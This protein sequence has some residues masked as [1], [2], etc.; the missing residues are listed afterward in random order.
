MRFR[1]ATTTPSLNR[2]RSNVCIKSMQNTARFRSLCTRL[3]LSETYPQLDGATLLL[4][5]LRV[6]SFG[7]KFAD[8][9]FDKKRVKIFS[10]T[11]SV[12]NLDLSDIESRRDFVDSLPIYDKDRGMRFWSAVSFV[13]RVKDAVVFVASVDGTLT[14]CMPLSGS[15]IVVE[16][17]TLDMEHVSFLASPEP[18]SDDGKPGEPLDINSLATSEA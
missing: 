1:P 11:K 14:A 18:S 5:D 7:A 8:S 16:P 12:A 9:A 2:L 3:G 4:P 10:N 13:D 6:L 15:V 17:I